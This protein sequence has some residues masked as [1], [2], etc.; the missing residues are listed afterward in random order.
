[1]VDDDAVVWLEDGRLTEGIAELRW[2]LEDLLSNGESTL[3][4]DVS[5]VERLTAASVAAMLWA[6]RR[7]M[8][9]RVRVV[10]RNPSRRSVHMLR[11]TG[12]QGAIDMEGATWSTQGLPKSL[13]GGFCS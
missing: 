1:M 13:R 4:I 2:G 6:K 12:L 11:R 10:L 9:R 3:V 8:A 7:C 5:R